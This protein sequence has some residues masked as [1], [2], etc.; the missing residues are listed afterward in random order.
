MMGGKDQH[1]NG[2]FA[3]LV[4]ILVML[5][6]SFLAS[7]LIMQVR[8]DLQIAANI[9]QRV[10]GR[11]LAEG[12][13]NLALFRLIDKPEV[14]FEEKIGGAVFLRG[15]TYETVLSTGKME[16]YAVSESGKM[17]LNKKTPIDLLKKFL[18]YHALTEEEVDV[19]VDSLLDWRDNDDLHRINGAEKDYYEE[20][21]KP[22]IPRNGQIE[23]PAEFF[24]LR[25]TESLRG[26]FDPY[27]VFT[28]KNGS[29]KVNINNLSPEMLA[30][31]VDDD[32]R[33]FVQ[34]Q[35]AYLLQC[36]VLTFFGVVETPI[37]VLLDD[38]GLF[39]FAHGWLPGSLVWI[40]CNPISRRQ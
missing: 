4:V 11:M 40:K 27:A 17:D 36:N 38:S 31:L 39:Y 19:V 5:I 15:R 13:V 25:G 12:G 8:T 2:G 29:G 10:V 7:Q 32:E 24:L 23:D 20:L 30:F 26:K 18:E 16:Y 34:H 37:G 21:E 6:T 28:V 22:Y 1:E 33:N 35:A 9:K 3:L 14:D